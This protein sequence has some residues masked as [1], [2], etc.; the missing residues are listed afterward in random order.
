MERMAKPVSFFYPQREGMMKK[1]EITKRGRWKL[2]V[3][4]LVII[5]LFL[6][7]IGFVK[8][9]KTNAATTL[10]ATIGSWDSIGLDHNQQLKVQMNL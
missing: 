6:F 5:F 1:M 10:T 4:K 9:P 8:I 7:Q 3:P 2:I